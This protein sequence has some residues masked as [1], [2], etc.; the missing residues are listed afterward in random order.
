MKDALP[1]AIFNLD[2]VSGH[3]IASGFF[4]RKALESLVVQLE[5]EGICVQKKYFL[6]SVQIL[7][8]IP[9]FWLIILTL[10]SPLNRIHEPLN[11]Y[12]PTHS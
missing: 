8:T 7:G 2:A 12:K 9:F 4:D 11:F 5:V 6:I 10:L 3:I 1:L